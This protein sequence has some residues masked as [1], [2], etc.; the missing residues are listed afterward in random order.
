MANGW[1][2]FPR[3]GFM[4]AVQNQV[5]CTNNY[6]K[7]ILNDPDTI[8]K[9]CPEKYVGRNYLTCNRC[10]SCTGSRPLH[11]LHNEVA[12]YPSYLAIK[13]GLSKGPSMPYYKYE[14]QSVLENC[15]CKLYSDIFRSFIPC[16]MTHSN[17]DNTNKCA[18]P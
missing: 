13:C 7:C 2:T 14:P 18:V 4:L 12:N 8:S 3:T 9:N 17:F 5:I 6:K 11:H 1:R 10:M 16:I 15:N